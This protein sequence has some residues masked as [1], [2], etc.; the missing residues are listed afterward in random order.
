MKN[1]LWTNGASDLTETVVVKVLTGPQLSLI[2]LQLANENRG[3]KEVVSHGDCQV[4]IFALEH[5]VD[6]QQI[7]A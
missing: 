4:S 5:F 7:F 6:C 3:P 2:S 1:M